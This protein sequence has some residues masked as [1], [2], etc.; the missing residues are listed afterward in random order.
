M[1]DRYHPWDDAGERHRDWL[2]R[3]CSLGG[4][5]EVMCVE[6]KV[7]LLESE[8]SKW[9][10]RCDLA[11][12]IAHIDLGHL[13]FD[14]RAEAAAVRYAAKRL[15]SRDDVAA[16]LAETLGDVTPET[17]EILG[18]DMPTLRARLTCLHPAERAAINL[19][20]SALLELRAA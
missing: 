17:A 5:H 19:K 4:L 1:I 6:R 18:V 3:R 20:L 15:L 2:I 14:D 12:A 10:R 13:Q 11:H 8:R 16:A 7:I 9:E